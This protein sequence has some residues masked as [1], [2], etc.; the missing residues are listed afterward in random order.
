MP[1]TW[2]LQKGLKICQDLKLLKHLKWE[3]KCTKQELGSFYHQF[4]LSLKKPFCSET[5]SNP[6]HIQSPVSHLTKVQPKNTK[7]NFTP[8]LNKPN[9]KSPTRNSKKPTNLSNPRPK[10]SLI[11]SPLLVI[12]VDRK[13]IPLDS[14]KS[15]KNSMN[16][17]LIK[18]PTLSKTFTMK[19]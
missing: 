17:K 2:G 13:A 5:S 11:S 6:R 18:T 15:N 14:A 7:N 10:L 12:N 4:D 19:P 3:M 8:N 16:Y 9:T 1:H